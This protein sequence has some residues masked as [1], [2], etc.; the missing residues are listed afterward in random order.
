MGGELE[1]GRRLARE[2]EN[3]TVEFERWFGRFSS[4]V[5]DIEAAA[6][7]SAEESLAIKSLATAV[8]VRES[9]LGFWKDMP[10][11]FGGVSPV[12]VDAPATTP[13]LECATSDEL[14]ST[15]GARCNIEA[16]LPTTLK[17]ESGSG[18]MIDFA[19]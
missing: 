8:E 4:G 16:A 1:A 14:D 17:T 3:A 5:V 6:E 12:T 19:I 7:W 2:S 15:A 18:L 13:V 10:L 11:T 9:R